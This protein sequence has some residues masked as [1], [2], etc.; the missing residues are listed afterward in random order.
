[1]GIIK[2][3]HLPEVEHFKLALVWDLFNPWLSLAAVAEDIIQ[4]VEA[5]QAVCLR[6]LLKL[7]VRVPIRSQWVQG[8]PAELRVLRVEFLVKV[9]SSGV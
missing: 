8:G 3:I 9:L 5:A 7:L 1:M 6:L 4:V 2:S